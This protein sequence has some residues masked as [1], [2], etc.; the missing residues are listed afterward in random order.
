MRI[1]DS[2]FDRG[3]ELYAETVSGLCYL[4]L[5]RDEFEEATGILRYRVDSYPTSDRLRISEVF[6]DFILNHEVKDQRAFNAYELLR[7]HRQSKTHDAWP[8]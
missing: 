1:V 2:L 8:T 4:F 6:R 3:T 5:Q 7:Q